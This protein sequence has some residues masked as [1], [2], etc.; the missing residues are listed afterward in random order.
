MRDLNELNKYRITD[1]AKL[2]HV[3][4]WAGDERSGSFIVPSPGDHRPMVV[5]AS[6]DAGWD[7]VSASREYRTPNWH[8][9]SFIHRLFFNENEVAMQLHVPATDHVN[10]HPYVLHLWRPHDRVIPLP[11][12]GFV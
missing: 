12:K 3:E 5:V 2:G 9:M 6:N 1:P 7:H 11:P 10:I 8:E 4:G